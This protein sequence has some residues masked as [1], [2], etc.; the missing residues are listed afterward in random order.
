MRELG[1][2]IVEHGPDFDEAKLRCEEIAAERK[3][4]YVHSANEPLLIAGVGT[5]ALE[6]FER[7]PVPDVILVP[8]GL[9]SGVCGAAIVAAEL[10]PGTQIIG[11]QATGAPAV[12]ESW[13]SGETI[14]HDAI[15][16]FAEGM[17]TR[18]PAELTLD[19]MRRLLSDIVLVT[20]E[21]LLWAM[22]WIVADT[23]NLPEPAGAASVAA[24]YKLRGQ[25]AGK[26]VVGILSGGNCD[27]RLLSELVENR[28]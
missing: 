21:E 24:A 12:T 23:H 20:D 18:A 8:I 3:L 11:V 1:A 26:T 10:S 2:E 13:R 16:T 7:L 5:M 4:R 27:L 14:T 22:R 19:I 15:H 25:L 17:A 6:I 28:K 9:G